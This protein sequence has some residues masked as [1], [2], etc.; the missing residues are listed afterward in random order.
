MTQL[1]IDRRERERRAAVVRAVVDHVVHN[2]T[3]TVTVQGLQQRLGVPQDAA[4][5]IVA[6]L[7]NAGILKEVRQ[8][9]WC[10]VGPFRS[11][12]AT[13]LQP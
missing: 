11:T 5:R 1:G 9:V 6:N 4:G 12:P 10:R 13:L 8:G 3:T 2:A 7:V